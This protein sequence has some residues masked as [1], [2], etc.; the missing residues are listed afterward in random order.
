MSL[1]LV[2]RHGGTH[3]YIRGTIRG[4]AVDE[5]TRTD[6]KK[7]A[8]TVRARREWELLESSVFGRKAIATFLEATVSYLKAG[9]ESRYAKRLAEYFGTTP[10]PKIDQDAIDQAARVLCP[11]AAPSTVNRQI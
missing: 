2:R 9:G 10:L 11:D 7:F 8:E 3:W 4:V 1:K 5:S 6:D